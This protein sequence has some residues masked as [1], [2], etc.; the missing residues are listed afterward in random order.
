MNKREVIEK[1]IADFSQTKFDEPFR[2][3]LL[4]Y[5]A[6]AESLGLKM[7][8]QGGV[9]EFRTIKGPMPGRLIASERLI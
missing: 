1:Y 9:F 3:R 4:P 7:W 6:L 5:Q 8:H 2:A